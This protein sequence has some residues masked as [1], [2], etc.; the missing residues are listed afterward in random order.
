MDRIEFFHSINYTDKDNSV[1]LLMSFFDQ[2]MLMYNLID[3]IRT[4]SYEQS[5]LNSI[6]FIIDYVSPAAAENN[7]NVVNANSMVNIYG[8]ICYVSALKI[9]DTGVK[10]TISK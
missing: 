8:S 4:V 6:Q 10:I 3:D 1:D 9:S 7:L 5:Y 2:Y